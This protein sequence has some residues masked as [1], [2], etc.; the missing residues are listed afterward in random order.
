[1]VKITPFFSTVKLKMQQYYLFLMW[2]RI[3]Q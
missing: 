2:V 3:C 1:M